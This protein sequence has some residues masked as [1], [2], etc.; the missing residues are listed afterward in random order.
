[1]V[2]CSSQDIEDHPGVLSCASP[3][4]HEHFVV[5]SPARGEQTT[6]CVS[7]QPKE[8]QTF[9]FRPF[10]TQGVRTMALKQYQDQDH[11]CPTQIH[12]ETPTATSPPQVADDRSVVTT[13]WRPRDVV[14]SSSGVHVATSPAAPPVVQIISQAAPPDHQPTTVEIELDVDLLKAWPA[15]ATQDKQYQQ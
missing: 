2:A 4:A 9:I 5:Y 1:M 10:Q 13:S 7:P 6:V 12:N 11:P 15:A 8:Q 3:Q 14:P